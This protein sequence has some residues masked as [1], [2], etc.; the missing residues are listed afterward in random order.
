LVRTE[1]GRWGTLVLLSSVLPEPGTPGFG[2]A[3]KSLTQVLPKVIDLLNGQQLDELLGILH[4]SLTIEAITRAIREDLETLTTWEQPNQ[5]TI[6]RLSAF[7]EDQYHLLESNISRQS[8][9]RGYFDPTTL[10]ADSLTDADSGTLYSPQAIVEGLSEGLQLIHAY[11]FFERGGLNGP[12]INPSSPYE[13]PEIG[14]LLA[15]AALWRSIR[16]LWAW[17]K[18]HGWRAKVLEGG[19]SFYIPPDSDDLLRYEVGNVRRE[20]FKLQIF[21]GAAE[22]QHRFSDSPALR[23]ALVESIEF[24]GPD[25]VWDASI[26]TAL[27]A[28]ACVL[29]GRSMMCTVATEYLHYEQIAN[30]LKIGDGAAVTWQELFACADVLAMLSDAYR[31]AAK[32]RLKLDN[33]AFSLNEIFLIHQP[34]LVAVLAECTGLSADIVSRCV[35]HLKLNPRRRSLEIWDTPLIPTEGDLLIVVPSVAVTGDPVRALENFT[36]QWDEGLFAARGVLLEREARD[37][38]ASI[39]GVAA[40]GPVTYFS[41]DEGRE[42]EFDVMARWEGNIF[43]LEAKCTKMVFDPADLHRAKSRVDHAARQLI[44]RKRVL[45]EEWAAVRAL[46]PSIC[47]EDIPIAGERIILIALTNVTQV[48]GAKVDDVIVLDE[49][50]FRRYF[51]DAG[52]EVVE[53]GGGPI[54]ELVALRNTSTATASD[55][56]RYLNELPQVALIAH[57]LKEGVHVFP[58]VRA[59]SPRVMAM[60]YGFTGLNDTFPEGRSGDSIPE[61]EVPEEGAQPRDEAKARVGED[62]TM[63]A[64]V[65]DLHASAW[66]SATC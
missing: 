35:E 24:P 29:T 44:L 56:F 61:A 1:P 62:M 23:D 64:D 18:H 31:T 15:L 10:I 59:T 50:A 5:E 30:D 53:L 28:R 46:V 55:F 21:A 17:V 39:E 41:R 26:D 54:S 34:R 58:Q 47:V 60:N 12:I 13:D 32:T 33:H 7:L 38:F 9:D 51:G 36:S 8:S 2:A 48:T 52:V 11:A 57:H 42:I 63:V 49:F 27:L 40:I 25:L 4:S 3:L 6:Y 45:L 16:E 22:H 37:F 43:L 66:Q 20:F 19:V 65:P 14:R